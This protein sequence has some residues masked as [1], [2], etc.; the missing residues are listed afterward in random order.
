MN[1]YQV[2]RFSTPNGVGYG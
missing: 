1:E 2:T